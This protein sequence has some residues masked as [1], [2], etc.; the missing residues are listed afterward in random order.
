[1]K[2][3]GIDKLNRM[4]QVLD[5][6]I[7]LKGYKYLNHNLAIRNWEKR[8]KDK[9]ITKSLI[10]QRYEEAKEKDRLEESGEIYEPF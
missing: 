4:I 5:K 6:G 3:W 1:M 9:H 2:D 10:Q 7:E 8:E